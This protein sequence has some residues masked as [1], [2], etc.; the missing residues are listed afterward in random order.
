MNHPA[1]VVAGAPKCGTTSLY[2]WLADH[3]DVLPSL[4]KE[5]Y[6]LMDRDSALYGRG[7]A[8][9]HEHGPA[10]WDALFPA[11]E[12]ARMEATPD[13][14]Y[15]RTAPEVLG[16]LDPCPLAV[17]VLREPAAR[18]RSAYRFFQA[19]LPVLDPSLCFA[20]YVRLLLDEPDSPRLGSFSL[21][22]AAAAHSVYAD[23]VPAWQRALPK[24]RL[25]LL[26][27]EQLRANPQSALAA[28]CRAAGLDPGFY[29][30]YGFPRANK[31]FDVRSQRLHKAK[32]AL[33]RVFPDCRLRRL[34]GRAYKAANLTRR[35]TRAADRAAT[36]RLQEF[37][38]P[39]N[40]RLARQTGLDLSPWRGE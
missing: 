1:I 10:G 37:F 25:Q 4:D 6:F 32:I 13:Y 18:V 40:A 17:V 31:S 27:F 11:G 29:A 35:G 16:G 7:R 20:E 19:V 22:R 38:A 9:W 3:P 12:G 15:Q 23:F 26:L 8:N 28:I 21:A 33:E 14:L 24:D 36:A 2:R 5:T 34:L 30:H 39:H